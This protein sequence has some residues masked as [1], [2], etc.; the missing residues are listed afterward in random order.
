MRIRAHKSVSRTCRGGSPWASV[1]AAPV[2][3]Q[4][5]DS[6]GCQ[7]GTRPNGVWFIDR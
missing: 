2:A 4:S 6:G 5:S 1:V 3:R 7:I